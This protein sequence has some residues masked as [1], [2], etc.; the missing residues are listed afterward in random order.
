MESSLKKRIYVKDVLDIAN[1][2]TKRID[3]ID[4][5]IDDF[6]SHCQHTNDVINP[7]VMEHKRLLSGEDG[8]VTQMAVISSKVKKLDSI[9]NKMSGLFWGS[10]A[11]GLGLLIK[12]FFFG[13]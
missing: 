10:I 5:K 2:N 12:T 7:A 4:G 11:T 8:I 13:S 1:K 3:G 9:D 6:E